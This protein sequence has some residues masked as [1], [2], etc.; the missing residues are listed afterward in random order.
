MVRVADDLG[1]PPPQV[2][3]SRCYCILGRVIEKIERSRER[4]VHAKRLGIEGLSRHG[5]AGPGG[6]GGKH[7]QGKAK[8][9]SHCSE[10]RSDSLS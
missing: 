7:Q 3:V 6:K 4:L 8:G 10:L 1:T 5:T 2:C 9:F